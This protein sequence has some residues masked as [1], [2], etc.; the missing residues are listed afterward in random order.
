MALVGKSGTLGEPGYFLVLALETLGIYSR[1]WAL[2]ISS[3]HSNASFQKAGDGLH[4]I[5]GHFLLLVNV[6]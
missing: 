6:S 1:L 3:H 2:R 5:H 4:V